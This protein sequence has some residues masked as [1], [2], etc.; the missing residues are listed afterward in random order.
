MKNM[1][2]LLIGL[3]VCCALQSH[4]YA[5]G[6]ESIRNL[7]REDA[8]KLYSNLEYAQIVP[9]LEMALS[10]PGNTK[11]QL[12][13]IYGLMGVVQVI[14]EN[15]DAARKAFEEMLVLDPARKLNP[16]L[17]PKILDFYETVKKS[18]VPAARASFVGRPTVNSAPDKQPSVNVSV[19]DKQDA[20]SKIDLWFRTAS[21]QRFKSAAMK[22]AG[23]G[24]YAGEMP[25]RTKKSA[26]TGLR[27]DYYLTAHGSDGNVLASLGSPERPLQFSI[28]PVEKRVVVPPGGVV[29]PTAW[30]ETWWFWTAVGVVVAGT[31]T[32][33][34]I[35]ATPGDDVPVGS[36]GTRQLP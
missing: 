36:L 5:Q 6:G 4:A 21:S 24:Q 32:G 13:Q 25:V 28:L 10:V 3:A 2:K 26:S 12:C 8:K 23:A 16:R 33:I 11:E 27:I 9:K 19:D 15:E 22:S 18:F 29:G 30:Y 1:T 20:I 7:H 17:S 14:L 35:A 31:T 34:V